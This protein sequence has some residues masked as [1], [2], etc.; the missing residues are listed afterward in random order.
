MS[1]VVKNLTKK[2]DDGKIALNNVSFE[3]EPKKVLGIIGKSGAGKT[4]LIRILRGSEK[5]N[6][7]SIEVFGKKENLRDV[8]A[9]HL[10]RN[11]ALWAEPAINN[12]IR[13][14]HAIREQSDESLPIEE[15]MPEYTEK[16]IEILK[17]VGLEDKANTFSNILS[18]GE[19]QRLIMG[20]QLAKIY[21]K[22]E[23]V[24]LLD[25]P[26]TM[27]CPASK[28]MILEIINNA[29]KKLN[30]TVILTS[31]L[32]EIHKYLCDECILLENG[33]I[34]SK[35]KPDEIVDEFLKD[36]NEEYVKKNSLNSEKEAKELIYEVKD[37]SKRYFVI[38]GGETLNLKNISFEVQKGEI[39]SILGASGTGKSVLLRIL[40]GLELPDTGEIL[41]KGIDLS[42]FGWE[43]MNLRSKM[44]IMHQ[45]F[46]LAHYS[47]VGELLKYRR[48]IKSSK[49]LLDAKEKAKMYEIPETVVDAL[50]QLLDLPDTERNNKLE[51]LGISQKILLSLF[52]AS[53][54]DIYSYDKLMNALDL[55]SEILNK[56]P[57]EL[58]GGQRVR[59]AIALQLVNQPEILLLDEPF[60]DLDPITL[61]DVSNY[62]KKINDMYGTTIVLISHHI[63]FIKEISDRAILIDNGTIDSE[64]KPDEICEKF[65]EKSTLKF[66]K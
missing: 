45:E 27:S 50:Y 47:T 36:M 4:T 59:V 34:K 26:V 5:F 19:K 49:V 66:C 42:H 9:I 7:G 20:R 54:E 32:P 61:R 52:N 1:I 55:D 12:I 28:K 15:D 11:F 23:G 3:V 57:G 51:K 46:S 17:L 60:G 24:L 13:K 16:A 48:N 65:I 58:S 56:K 40:G 31:H 44:G 18:G 2:Y 39:L 8:T 37:I 14:L 25:E 22:G 62:L 33:E 64:G 53:E 6:E 10:Q 63:E 30:I 43:R 29:R 38:N 21:E 35:G 41:L